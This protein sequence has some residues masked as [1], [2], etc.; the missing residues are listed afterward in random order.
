MTGFCYFGEETCIYLL[1]SSATSAE[2][3]ELLANDNGD[4]DLGRAQF[5]LFHP[6][7]VSQEILDNSLK[8]FNLTSR[9]PALEYYPRELA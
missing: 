3:A 1:P 6:D 4:L 5:F 8:N 7:I 9:L 2:R